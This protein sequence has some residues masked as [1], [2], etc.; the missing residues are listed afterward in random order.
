MFASDFFNSAETRGF[1]FRRD[2]STRPR[3]LTRLL[4]AERVFADELD[5]ELHAPLLWQLLDLLQ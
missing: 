3:A 5:E 2:N 4:A 1:H